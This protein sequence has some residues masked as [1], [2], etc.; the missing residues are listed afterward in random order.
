LRR[1]TVILGLALAAGAGGL[2]TGCSTVELGDPPA[3]VNACRPSQDFFANGG[4]WDMFLDKDYGGRKC[5][6]AS[7]HADA[8]GRPLSLKVPPEP[9][10]P[11]PDGGTGKVPVP[12]PPI[13]A[14]NYRSV[15]ENMNCSNV[16]SSPLL[17][18]PAGL[19]TH[20]GGKLIDP[21]GPEATLLSTWVTKP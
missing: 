13:W 21:N 8:A 2:A 20:G 10:D 9:P 18:N 11:N 14:A 3:D 5:S 7:C 1:A 16:H 4:V 6:D 19:V 12:L 17:A 15:T